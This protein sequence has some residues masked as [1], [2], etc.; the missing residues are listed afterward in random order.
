MGR[1]LRQGLA[2]APAQPREGSSDAWEFAPQHGLHLGPKGSP[3][4]SLYT[5]S[6]PLDEGSVGA[7][8]VV[9]RAQVVGQYRGLPGRSSVA[10]TGRATVRHLAGQA[11]QWLAEDLARSVARHRLSWLHGGKVVCATAREA[12][13]LPTDEL[14]A[15]GWVLTSISEEGVSYSWG[16]GRDAMTRHT[17]VASL[18]AAVADE[19][20]PPGTE[21][22]GDAAHEQLLAGLIEP[23]RRRLAPA[24][25]QPFGENW[26]ENA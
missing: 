15:S 5:V 9:P 16:R 6:L 14:P 13:E 19:P 24:L 4:A 26:T 20:C 3:R 23:R 10:Q 7:W 22:P 21:G 18:G 25:A 17:P 1:G 12:S 8:T 2:A 11:R